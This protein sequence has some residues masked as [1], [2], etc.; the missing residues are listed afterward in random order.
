MG[1]LMGIEHF[2]EALMQLGFSKSKPPLFPYLFPCSQTLAV[3][4]SPLL[5]GM[6]P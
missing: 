4:P 3:D 2:N 6:S 5:T 1:W